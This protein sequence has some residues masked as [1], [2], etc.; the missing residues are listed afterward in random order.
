VQLLEVDRL[1]CPQPLSALDSAIISDFPESSEEL[2]EKWFGFSVAALTTDS[3]AMTFTAA[4]MPK[5]TL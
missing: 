2:Q 1:A 4:A 5:R 3:G